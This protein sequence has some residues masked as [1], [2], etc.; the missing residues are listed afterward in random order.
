MTNTIQIEN[1]KEELGKM[2]ISLAEIAGDLPTPKNPIVCYLSEEKTTGGAFTYTIPSGYTIDDFDKVYLEVKYTMSD[3]NTIWV[4]HSDFIP[5]K[6]INS[7]VN[8]NF[9]K[10]ITFTTTPNRGI[11]FS[12]GMRNTDVENKQIRLFTFPTPSG[13]DDV[14]S[15]RLMGE[16]L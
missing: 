15:V 13:V 14:I 11:S 10:M 1:L 4:T 16:V 6:L 9:L 3:P 7:G 5:L 8:M 2:T 12:W